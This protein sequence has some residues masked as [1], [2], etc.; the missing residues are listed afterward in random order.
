MPAIPPTLDFPVS[1]MPMDVTLDLDT[2]PATQ[3]MEELPPQSSQ[4][5][6]LIIVLP[7]EQNLW[8]RPPHSMKDTLIKIMEPMTNNTKPPSDP[9]PM[10]QDY[11]RDL[12]VTITPYLSQDT[13]YCYRHCQGIL[14]IFLLPT[15]N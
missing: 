14:F 11:H 13:M 10:I 2:T 12:D 8:S 5:R 7:I 15:S 1:A 9:Q 4:P 6:L 3:T